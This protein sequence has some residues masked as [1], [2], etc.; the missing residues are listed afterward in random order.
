ME[1]SVAAAPHY[2]VV[3]FFVL[4]TLLFAFLA[5]RFAFSPAPVFRHFGIGL[6]WTAAAFAVWS[7]IVW[8]RPEN[9]HLWT[10]VGAALFFPGYLFF[11]NAATHTWL[12]R[13]RRLA[14]GL[15]GLYLVVL[16]VVRTFIAPSE[17][18]FSERGLFYF[19]TQPPVLL[20]YIISLVGAVM[21]A[22][23]AVA[24]N[25][26]VPWVS[27]ATSVCINLVVVCAV[28]LLT[29]YDDDLQ[30]YNG[31]LLGAALLALSVIYLR[32]KPA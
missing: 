19:N 5:W 31:Y 17:P 32:R 10:S 20:L 24:R 4:G 29:S 23:N 9:L 28:I 25:I 6:A 12:P 15:A 27:R 14:L 21:S 11:L 13:N 8:I 7:A 2:G 22:G 30:T 3:G 1:D 18:G 16:F 26:S